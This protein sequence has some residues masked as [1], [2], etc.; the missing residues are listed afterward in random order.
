MIDVVTHFKTHAEAL[1]FKFDFGTRAMLNFL[2]SN[3]VSTDIHL[4]L[5]SPLSWEQPATDFMGG[6]KLAVG[7]FLFVVKSNLDNVIYRQK[8][9]DESV[10]KYLKNIEPLFAEL[11]KFKNKI[12]CSDYY[13][14]NWKAV[15]AYNV[16]DTNCDGLLV[17]FTVGKI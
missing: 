5:F 12:V 9:M 8:G 13:I 3:K 11:E 6:P 10:T 15:D 16:L 4:L 2:K 17:D 1:N 7:N 14:T